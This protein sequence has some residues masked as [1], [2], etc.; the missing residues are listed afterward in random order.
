MTSP[1]ARTALRALAEQARKGRWAGEHD[2]AF[3]A[4]ATPEAVL[5]LLDALEAREV[6]V[7]HL[8]AAGA[9][10]LKGFDERMFVRNVERDLG[11][12]MWALK[13][14]PYLKALAVIQR[15]CEPPTPPDPE[16]LR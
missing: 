3:L 1:E 14:V 11:D 6:E 2:S 15:M 4:A 7:A 12:V 8:K 9:V 5:A 13:F 10:V 16:A